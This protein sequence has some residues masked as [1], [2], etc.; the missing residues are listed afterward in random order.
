MTATVDRPVPDPTSPVPLP[1][2]EQA[3][4]RARWLTQRLL[5]VLP[6]LM[7]RTGID[8]WIVLGR[9]YNGGPVLGTVLPAP[10]LSA[11]RRSILLFHRSDDGVTAAAVSRYPVGQFL[12]AWEP[13][14]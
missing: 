11:R 5:D 2:R 13:E 6:G 12:T 1:L 10:W 14:D 7:D 8:L 3:D 9:E 4:V